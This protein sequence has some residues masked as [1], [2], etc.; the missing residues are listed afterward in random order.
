MNKLSCRYWNHWRGLPIDLSS[1][2]HSKP[3]VKKLAITRDGGPKVIQL[4]FT[5]LAIKAGISQD[6]GKSQDILFKIVTE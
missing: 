5:E 1:T 4:G 2:V 3:S 6:M